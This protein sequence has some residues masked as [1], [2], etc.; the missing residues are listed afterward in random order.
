V[1]EQSGDMVNIE[2]VVEMIGVKQS[3]HGKGRG[4]LNRNDNLPSQ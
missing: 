1:R 4:V 3:T 2:D